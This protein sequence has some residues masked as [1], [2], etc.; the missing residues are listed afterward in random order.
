MGEL[1]GGLATM[2]LFFVSLGITVYLLTL[3][4][5][6]VKAAERIASAAEHSAAYAYANISNRGGSADAGAVTLST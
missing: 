3:A 5:R 1:I 4:T 6:L 2:A